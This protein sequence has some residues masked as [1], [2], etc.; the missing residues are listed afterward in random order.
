M[1]WPRASAHYHAPD[2]RLARKA[3]PPLCRPHQFQH[4]RQANAAL[5]RERDRF[6]FGALLV[7]GAGESDADLMAA[8]HGD[9]AFRRG[10][11]LI[12]DFALP[13]AVRGSVGAEIVKERVA[14][15]NAAVD[16]QHDAGQT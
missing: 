4:R 14:A 13:A 10:M 16:Q 1:R 5:A 9:L 7:A 6:E 11:L 12:E 2:A 15:E 3:T 8:E